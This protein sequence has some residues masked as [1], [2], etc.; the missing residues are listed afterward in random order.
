M[1]WSK[2]KQKEKV[3]NMVRFD[4]ASF[5][6]LASEASKYQVVIPLILP[7]RP[8]VTQLPN[9]SSNSDYNHYKELRDKSR[10]DSSVTIHN[11]KVRLLDSPSGS[12][13]SLCRSWVRNGVSRENQPHSGEVVKT[14]PRPLPS[15]V[16]GTHLPKKSESNDHD[17]EFSGKEEYSD[18]VV[19]FSSR[20]LLEG[21]IK[22]AKRVRA[23]LREERLRRIDRYRYR[24]SLLLPRPAELCRNDAATGS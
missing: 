15:T 16:A 6:K 1:E 22:R 3:S 19:H 21:H 4:Q 10:D 12:L 2:G 5:D 23:R 9:I 11:R 20:D 7:D 13:Y 8:G 17:G 18:S 24:L 14:L